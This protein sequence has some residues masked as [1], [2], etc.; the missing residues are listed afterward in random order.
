[1]KFFPVRVLAV[2]LL[3]LAAVA[4]DA[5]ISPQHRIERAR[6][7]IATG[8]WG[9][10]AIE[11]RKAVKAEPGNAEA[12]LLLARLSLDAAD[13]G[14]AQGNLDRAVKF[15]AKGPKVDALRARTWLAT[16]KAKDLIAAL[17]HGAVVLPEPDRSIALARAYNE[18]QQ[19]DQALAALWA[20][21]ALQPAPTD[22]RL[23]AA[24]ALERQGKSDLALQQIDSAMAAD[25][26]SAQAPLL[27]ARILEARGQFAGADGAF[28]LALQRMSG[29]TPLATRA[30]ALAGLT[31]SRLAQ[32]NVEA[33]AKSSAEL[34]QL[35]PSAPIA[36]LLGARIQLAHGDRIGG[37][38]VL[39][40]L[41]ANVPS[42]VQARLLL[43]AAQLDR[44]D[45]EQARQ[46]LE[47]VIQQAPDNL[48]ARE[49]LA[50]V[51][52]KL[53]QPGEALKILT[54]ALGAHAMDAQL[55]SLIG[56]AGNL[57][58]N[59]NAA[60]QALEKSVRAH[61]D[62]RGLTLN[63]AQAYLGANRPNDALALLEKTDV[64]GEDLQ[65]DALLVSALNAVKGPAAAGAAV[66]Q[67]LAAHPNERG[68]LNLAAMYFASQSQFERA[69]ALLHQAL[70]GD[71]HDAPTLVALARV[72]AATG[73]M[74]A[75]EAS[76]RSAL[77]AQPGNLAI[78][79]MLARAYFA[80]GDLK[81]ANAALDQAVAAQPKN[82]GLVNDAGMLLLQANQYD[83]ALAHFRKASDLAPGKAVYWFNA[84][85]AQLALN[86]PLAARESLQKASQIEPRWLPP[87]SALALIDL[88]DKHADQAL[89]RVN[90]FVA[91]EPG[92][93]DALALK[94]D[95]NAAAGRYQDAEA[96]FAEAQRRRPAAAIAVKLFEVRRAAGVAKPEEPLQQ[97]LAQRPNDVAV[98][99]E[100]ASF[101]LAQQALRPAAQEF[102]TI[103]R[104]A[105]GNVIALNNLAWAYSKLKDPRALS[106]AEQAYKLAPGQANVADTFGWILAGKHETQRALPLL[107]QAAKAAP[108]DPE[109]QYHYAFVLVQAGRRA[110]ARAILAKLLAGKQSFD[111][112]ADAEHLYAELKS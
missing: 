8:Q 87:V 75:A 24:E 55:Y 64:R 95:V 91:S 92:D 45:L 14:D 57:S 89:A 98:R 15:G 68:V 79:F 37:I 35:A 41:V 63:L 5:F 102:E 60:L 3:A 73:N 27:R 46:N 12:W 70:A 109:M 96:A 26:H 2:A 59:P 94:G 67:L 17:Q 31:E 48:A 78:R 110:E 18:L 112:R 90:R 47:Q 23:A 28:A 81:Q 6:A 104:Q 25:A 74:A 111:S 65:R 83:A 40:R 80:S 1:M 50:R 71:P 76:L 9:S 29:A 44:G 72:D 7:E 43:G 49:L 38:A 53:N 22:A 54:P 21:L 58:G 93:A 34:S 82:A 42:Y 85:R 99:M 11:L 100:L 4:C 10:A 56:A 52:L 108:A 16:G 107:A 32:G 62:N 84:G 105:P 66:N 36:Q 97:W 101:Y 30:A 13:P 86:Q 33:A 39:E 61:P 103:V 69:R 88:R 20:A 19:P 106:V 51:R 77:A